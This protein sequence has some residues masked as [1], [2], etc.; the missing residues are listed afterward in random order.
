MKGLRRLDFVKMSES[1]SSSSAWHDRVRGVVLTKATMNSVVMNYL[2]VEGHVEAAEAFQKETGTSAG[3]D[4]SSISNRR[5]MRMSLEGGDLP[6]ALTLAEQYLGDAGPELHFALR[7]QQLLELIRHNE[8]AAAIGLAQKELAPRAEQNSA[9]RA[10]LERTMLL[11]A[12]EEPESSP[13][14][15]ELLSQRQRQRTASFLNGWVL[16]AEGHEKE[17]SLCMLLRRLHWAQESLQHRCGP[18][19]RIRNFEEALPRLS[20]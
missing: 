4:L 9:L 5:V 15:A 17:A 7:Q 14:G 3:H 20:K 16:A 8:V 11:L 10:E 2:I 6:T 1:M 13:G 18:F 19:P 12:F